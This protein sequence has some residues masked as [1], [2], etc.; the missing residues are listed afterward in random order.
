MKKKKTHLHT[1]FLKYLLEKYSQELPDEETNVS[2]KTLEDEFDEIINGKDEVQD[3]IEND[4]E[5]ENIENL[6]KEYQLLE[7]IHKLKSN[8]RV[9]K[10]K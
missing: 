9:Y 8:G 7:K 10:R 5:D 3:E 1:T 6:V 2:D 4:E